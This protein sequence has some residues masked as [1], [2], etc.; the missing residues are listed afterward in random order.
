MKYQPRTL[1]QWE[2]RQTYLVIGGA[3]DG[4]THGYRLGFSEFGWDELREQTEYEEVARLSL[5]E[6]GEWRGNCWTRFPKQVKAPYTGPNE[7]AVLKELFTYMRTHDI[8]VLEPQ[9]LEMLT[10]LLHAGLR[11]IGPE[12]VQP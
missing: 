6:D 4:H 7:E 10:R 3:D 9:S 11:I 5:D 1:A 12:E 2:R 8:P